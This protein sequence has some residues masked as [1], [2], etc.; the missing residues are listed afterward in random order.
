MLLMSYD[1]YLSAE[2]QLSA[3]KSTQLLTLL[4]AETNVF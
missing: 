3:V 2:Y 1:V 4:I